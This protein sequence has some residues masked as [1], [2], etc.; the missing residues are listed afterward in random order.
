MLV[1]FTPQ[2]I[3]QQGM[4]LALAAFVD[5]HSRDAGFGAWVMSLRTPLRLALCYASLFLVLLFGALGSLP[6]VYFAF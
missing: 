2:R 3:L 4:L 5:W 1:G 6:G